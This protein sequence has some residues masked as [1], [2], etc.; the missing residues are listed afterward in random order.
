MSRL[1]VGVENLHIFTTA[2][3]LESHF[4]HILKLYFPPKFPPAF[5]S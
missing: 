1:S 3:K 2:K 4:A 5:D